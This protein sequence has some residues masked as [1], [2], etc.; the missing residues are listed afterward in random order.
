MSEQP[1][2][3]KGKGFQKG[4]SGNPKGRPPKIKCIPDILRK[5][6]EE[7][8]DTNIGKSTRLDVVMRKVFDFAVSGKSWAVEFIAERTEGKPIQ[9]IDITGDPQ[10]LAFSIISAESIR[11]DDLNQ[12][13]NENGGALNDTEGDDLAETL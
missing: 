10:P 1:E 5:I 2:Q 3:L 6:G 7:E 8:V 12:A 9:S 13:R 4:K 11:K